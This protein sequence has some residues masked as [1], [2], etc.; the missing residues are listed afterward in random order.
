MLRRNLLDNWPIQ[1]IGI[2]EAGYPKTLKTMAN[3]PAL[4]YY[5][6]KLLADEK[7]FAIVGTRRYSDYGKEIAFAF[8]REL[9]QA[10]LTIVSGMAH[11]IDTLAHQGV[12]EAAGRTIAV[13]GTGL[14]EQTIYPQENLGLAKQIL[15]KDGCLLSEYPPEYPGSKYTFPQR[16]RIVSALSLGVLVV[17]AKFKSGALITANWARKQN[18]K[19]FAIPGNIYAKNSKGPHLLIR[20]GA[21]LVEKPS[22]ILKALGLEQLP[23]SS[24]T[25]PTGKVAGNTVEQKILQV[26][27]QGSLHIDTIITGTKLSASDVASSISLLELNERIKNLGGD[28]YALLR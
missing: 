1:K 25:L 14:A 6:G 28:V 16:N 13:L 11:G 23:L 27:N 8:G 10:G 15:E 18:K 3:T 26:L 17:E 20:Q 12:L 24:S 21:T 19:I 7:S 5:R 2:E 22:E 4:L 9:S